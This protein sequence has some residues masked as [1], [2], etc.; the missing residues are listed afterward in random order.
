M[1]WKKLHAHT[2]THEYNEESSQ[3]G[4]YRTANRNETKNQVAIFDEKCVL[5]IDLIFGVRTEERAPVMHIIYKMPFFKRI[6]FFVVL[7]A[8]GRFE[9]A[10]GVTHSR[11]IHTSHGIVIIYV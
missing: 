8:N 11:C 5:H 1:K 10:A 4:I 7:Y 6:L 3:K 9:N 2:H